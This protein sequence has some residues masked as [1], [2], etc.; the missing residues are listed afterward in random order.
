M[1]SEAA[2]GSTKQQYIFDNTWQ[3]QR[4]RLAALEAWLDPGT[5]RHLDALGVA[6]GWQCLEVGA[7]GG[8]IAEWLSQRVGP[9][10]RVV[11]TDLDTRFVEPLDQPN[12][13]ARRH[14]IV[15]DE[16][17][18]GAFD[19]VHTRFLLI[20]LP[21]RDKALRKMVA[22]L[23]PG[24]WL[25]VEE[26]DFISGVADPTS[27]AEAAALFDKL[28]AAHLR[29]QEARGIDTSYGR[30]LLS[31][32]EA[33]GLSDVEA[34]GRVSILRFGAG[35]KGQVLGRL[36]LMQLREPMIEAGLTTQPE[37]D[38]LMALLDDPRFAFMT[39]V[40]MAAWGRR[41]VA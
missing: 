19:L 13:E 34:E 28:Y 30:R 24:G 26:P 25:L 18:E 1:T 20:H 36:T 10:G 5:T 15:T 39:M 2:S 9:S 21:E 22:A 37:F 40:V 12:L 38:A 31:S 8:S 3:Q 17:E 29:V 7:G 41:P 14:N 32:L 6:Q 16:L 35:S 23:K 33:E 27:G 4:Q 11:A